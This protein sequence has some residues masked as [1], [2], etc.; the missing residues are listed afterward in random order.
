M[1][2]AIEHAALDSSALFLANESQFS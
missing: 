2:I 1:N